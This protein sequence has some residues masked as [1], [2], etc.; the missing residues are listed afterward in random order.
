M[1]FSLQPRTDVPGGSRDVENLYLLY[2]SMRIN[3]NVG[4]IIVTAQHG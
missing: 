4:E 2:K 1:A 3:I